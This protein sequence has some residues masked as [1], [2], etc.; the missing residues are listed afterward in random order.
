MAQCLSF[1]FFRLSADWYRL[2][3]S[4]RERTKGILLKAMQDARRDSL[5]YTYDASLTHELDFL[6]WM[7]APSPD[8]LRAFS[9]LLKQS[10][11]GPYL[12]VPYSFFSITRRSQYVDKF[13][14]DH[15][16]DRTKVVVQKRP[17]LFV[18]PFVKTDEW[19][20]LP[21]E[22]RQQMMDEHIQIGH[23]YPKIKI[24][25]SY[26]FGLDDPEFVLAFEG[27]SLEEFVQLIMDLRESAAR[28]YTKSDTP[29]FT[30]C[31]EEPEQLF[32]RLL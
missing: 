13:A 30:C 7:I 29:I 28:P 27:D 25:T 17:F 23:K 3:A 26:A 15:T 9:A 21:F 32:D 5:L 22:K 11:L 31:Y 10:W 24:H 2:A 6:I 1:R 12:K 16:H 14:E 20:M 8:P 18:Y 19:Y 4:Q